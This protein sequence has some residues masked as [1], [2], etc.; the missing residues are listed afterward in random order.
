MRKC[1]ETLKG[2]TQCV[3]LCFD[4]VDLPEDTD[5]RVPFPG[6]DGGVRLSALGRDSWGHLVLPCEP[7]CDGTDQASETQTGPDWE[8]A[9]CWTLILE[10]KPDTSQ[11]GGFRRVIAPLSRPAEWAFQDHPTH[12]GLIVSMRKWRPQ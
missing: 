4:P 8:Q 6:Q 1:K 10:P 12:P 11:I 2:T 7:A 5:N 9:T 3:Q